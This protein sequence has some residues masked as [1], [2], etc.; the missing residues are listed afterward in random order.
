MFI[1]DLIKLA[2]E[3]NELFKNCDNNIKK[4]LLKNKIKTR[5]WKITFS[6]VLTY[7]FN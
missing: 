5:N 2:N 6:N 4:E 3:L 7:I 1:N